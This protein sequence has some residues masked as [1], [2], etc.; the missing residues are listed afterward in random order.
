MRPSI[1]LSA[2]FLTSMVVSSSKRQGGTLESIDEISF[3]QPERTAQLSMIL[4]GVPK[5]FLSHHSSLEELDG[6]E[7]ALNHDLPITENFT[8]DE[9]LAQDDET[10]IKGDGV[11][12]I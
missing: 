10:L 11:A 5:P 6:I 3:V 9:L 2:K 7:P 1:S 12:S 8:E 4:E